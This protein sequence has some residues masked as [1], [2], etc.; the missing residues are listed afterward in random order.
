MSR[1]SQDRGRCGRVSGVG[2]LLLFENLQSARDS[3]SAGMQMQGCLNWC[4][5]ASRTP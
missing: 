2:G 1:S 3:V 4:C 5:A